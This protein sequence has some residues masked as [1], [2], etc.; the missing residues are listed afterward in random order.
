MAI[1]KMNI[2]DTPNPRAYVPKELTNE[3]FVGDVD[4]LANAFTATIIRP[5]TS[6]KKAKESLELVLKDK[7]LRM[8]DEELAGEDVTLVEFRP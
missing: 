5:G 7:E 8:I 6:L 4:I 1:L 2:P 3:G